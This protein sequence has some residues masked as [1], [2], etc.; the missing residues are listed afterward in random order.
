MLKVGDFVMYEADGDI[1]IVILVN[2]DNDCD[3]KIQW[4]DGCY[5]WHLLS[6]LE[7]L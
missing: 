5:D 6:E 7:V 1:G 3:Y 2:I 4:S